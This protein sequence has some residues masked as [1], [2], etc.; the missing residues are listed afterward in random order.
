MK[1][2][3]APLL[4]ILA[5][6]GPTAAREDPAPER[7]PPP[8]ILFLFTDD[9]STAAISAYGS[10]INRTPNI[11]RLAA[12]GML[13][14]SNFCTNSICAPSRAVIL[15]GKHSPSN[16]VRDNRDRFDGTQETF[17]KALQAA[18]YTTAMIGKWHLKSDPTGFDHWEVLPGQ[19]QYYQPDFRTAEGTQRYEGYATDVTT[20]LALDWLEHGRDPARPFLLMCQHKAPHRTWMPGPQHLDTYGDTLIPEPPTLFDDYSGRSDAAR[21]QEMEIDRHMYLHYDLQ[22]PPLDPDTEP[23]GPD[24]WAKGLVDRLTPEQREAWDAAFAPRNEAFREA[25]LQGAELVRWKYQ[26]Y[27]KNYLRCIASVDDSI[28]R[29]LEYLDESGL[30]SNTIVIYSSDQ[31]FF[32]GEHGWYDKRFMYE[33]SLRMPLVVRWPGQVE[34]GSIQEFMTQNIDFAPTFLE[35]AG[36]PVPAE[37]QGRS[38]LPLLQGERPEDWREEIY[39]EYFERGAHNVQPHRGVRTQRYKLIHFH[40][41]DQWELFDLEADPEELRNL[42]GLPELSGVQ[43]DL[44]SSLHQLHKNYGEPQGKDGAPQ[45]GG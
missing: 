33:P 18:G 32:L 38:L 22:V 9:H 4:L 44:T 30:A 43:A 29:M 36:A 20:D 17:P 7:N 40:E 3:P 13:F 45:Q 25:D 6:T 2:M 23:Q 34:P 28:G 24:R 37:I 15:T 12:E 26:R 19:G 21:L 35:I 41:L 31:G 11:D 42:Y 39:Y 14:E 8:N 10:R 16:G 1:S 27:I 5:C